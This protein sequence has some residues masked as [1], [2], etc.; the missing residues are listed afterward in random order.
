MQI[1][2]RETDFTLLSEKALWRP[3]TGQLIIADIHLGK[4]SHFRKAGISIPADSVLED[5]RRLDHLMK[6]HQPKE[7]IL[8]G[9]LFHSSYNKEWHLF[10]AFLDSFKHI[11]FILVKGNHDILKQ[12]RYELPNFSVIDTWED[13]LFLYS[14]EP[15][16]HDTKFVLSGHVHPGITLSGKGKQHLSL[17]CFYISKNQAVLPAFGKLTGLYILDQNKDDQYYL[18]YNG[19]IREMK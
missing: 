5:M 12:H 4:A 15:L 1:R 8:L 9:D 2:I 6:A 19:V 7:V 11:Q 10:E 18:V 14:H 17:P 16:E 13:N 3:D